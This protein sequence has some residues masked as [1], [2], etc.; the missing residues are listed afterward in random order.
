MHQ[1]CA[2][3]PVHQLFSGRDIVVVWFFLSMLQYICLIVVC[4]SFQLT[5]I[6]TVCS[7]RKWLHC[8]V[9]Y[10]MGKCKNALSQKLTG[11][12]SNLYF[13]LHDNQ[14]FINDL[15]AIEKPLV[16]WIHSSGYK[17]GRELRPLFVWKVLI[18]KGKLRKFTT[19]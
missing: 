5:L 16:N 1:Q 8:K 9:E 18:S 13:I 15:K 4:K 14:K 11:L 6:I 19:I 2:A 7:D 17:K 3:M 12:L 10:T